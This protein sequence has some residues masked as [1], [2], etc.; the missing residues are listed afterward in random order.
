MRLQLRSKHTQ[1]EANSTRDRP[2]AVS[3]WQAGVGDIDGEG[4]MDDW[5]SMSRKQGWKYWSRI[6]HW[7][8]MEMRQ[9]VSM[10]AK[11]RKASY[12]MH[13]ARDFLKSRVRARLFGHSRVELFGVSGGRSGGSPSQIPTTSRSIQFRRTLRRRNRGLL[14]LPAKLRNRTYH[15]LLQASRSP[16]C[17]PSCPQERALSRL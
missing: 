13:R 10:H 8:A 5:S 6:R 12:T 11:Y 17:T 1:A 9:S 16:T 7:A 14:R 4:Y 3:G 2:V 15:P